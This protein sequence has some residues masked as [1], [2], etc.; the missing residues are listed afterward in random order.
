MPFVGLVKRLL[1]RISSLLMAACINT[2]QII[3]LSI[4]TAKAISFRSLLNVNREL[5][6]DRPEERE[7]ITY[8]NKQHMSKTNVS[9]KL[10]KNGVGNEELSSESS[11][12]KASSNKT[13]QFIDRAKQVHGDRY[14]YSKVDYQTTHNPV[15]II[16]PTHGVF[17]Q[18]PNSHIS[19]QAGCRRCFFERNANNIR[20]TTNEFIDR[21]KQ[22]HGDRYDYSKVDYTTSKGRVTIICPKHGAFQQHAARHIHGHGC[23]KCKNELVHTW[24]S[25]TLDDFITKAKQVHGDRYDYSKVDY[26]RSNVHVTIVCSK[27]GN[28]EQTPNK[29]LSG[30][31]CRR[32]SKSGISNKA[33]A[34]LRKM[35]LDTGHHIIGADI[36]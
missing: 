23:N 22:V 33:I 24:T 10:P 29:H 19:K 31:G 20:Y 16:C 1:F 2:I 21:A 11:Q 17:L 36:S 3:G 18:T 15:E 7:N 14:D 26:T 35:E 5:K 34:W 32:C 8:M 30:S 4:E 6:P 27:H 13:A 12:N 25:S 28:F 9:G